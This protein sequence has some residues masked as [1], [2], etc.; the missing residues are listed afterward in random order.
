MIEITIGT[1][2]FTKWYMNIDPGHLR[3]MNFLKLKIKCN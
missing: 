1:E 2:F 3:V